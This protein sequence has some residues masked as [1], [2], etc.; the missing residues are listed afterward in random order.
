[1]KRDPIRDLGNWLWYLLPAN[2]ILLRVVRGGGRRTRDLWY[3][4]G[5]LAVLLLVFLVAFLATSNSKNASLVEVAKTSTRTFQLVAMTQLFLMCFLAPVFTASAIT[6]ERD[7]ETYNILLTTPLTNAQIIFGSL[8]SRL[9]FVLVLLLSGIPVFCITMIYGGVTLNQILLSAAVAACTAI[10]T[11]SLAILVSMIK[12]GTRRTIFSFFLSIGMYLLIVYGLGTQGWTA[13]SEAPS[14]VDTT[15]RMSCL[16]PFHP[17]LALEVGLNHIAPPPFSDVAH[18]GW[19][20]KYLLAYPDLSYCILTILASITMVALSMAF[21]RRGALEGES[22]FWNKLLSRFGR[23]PAELEERRRKPRHVWANPVAWREA[24][25]RASA[26]SSGMMRWLLIIGGA[27]AALG[28]MGY[29]INGSP[30]MWEGATVDFGA[31]QARHYITLLVMIE[32]ALILLVA[33][34]ASSTSMTRER[35]S[36]TM[37][38]LI[39][40]PLTPQN[41]MWGKLRGLI[42][43]TVPLLA[44]P[45]LTLAVFAV[46]GMIRAVPVVNFEAVV[47][48]AVLMLVYTGVACVIGLQT[49]IKQKKTVKAVVISVI[50]V[51]LFCVISFFIA[52]Q[53]VTTANDVGAALAPLT[54]FTALKMIADPSQ[55]GLEVQDGSVRIMMM[56]GTIIAACGWG[57]VCVLG[58]YKSLVKNFD[59]TIR[60]QTAS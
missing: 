7:A 47:E 44:V 1:M 16:T 38:I 2:P 28:I 52:D 48:V 18:R 42:S 11:G 24:T 33:T 12:I 5:Y 60:R 37:D 32:F 26:A 30:I 29:L 40:T 46:Y 17:F 9:F 20:T 39:A 31:Q 13:V 14:N 23:R 15:R 10:I 36:N 45:I 57:G 50:L 6:Q 19:P 59:M 3:R 43:F 21:V 34:N 58:L 4:F 54:P 49:S 27:F 25:T 8:L 41:I 55:Y 56:V 22:T 35:D 53:I 51:S